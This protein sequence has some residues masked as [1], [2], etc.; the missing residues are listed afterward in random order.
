MAGGARVEPPI[1]AIAPSP[2]A[3]VRTVPG[4]ELTADDLR[5]WA[6]TAMATYKVPLVE[7]V[8]EL[9]LTPTGKIRKTELSAR[10]SRTR[11]AP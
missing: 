3:F 11:T 2:Y 7:L 10:A 8:P 9:P 4:A 5:A 1:I 6:R